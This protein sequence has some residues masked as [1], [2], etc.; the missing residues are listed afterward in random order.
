MKMLFAVAMFIF[1]AC[2]TT[3]MSKPIDNYPVFLKEGHRGARGYVPENTIASMKKGV[4]LG[5][6]VIEVDVYITRDG[7]VLI[8]HDPYV[9]RS[10]STIPGLNEISADSAKAYTWHQMNYT[11]IRRIDV[12]SKGNPAFPQ[13]VKQP[14]YM[15]LLGELIDS[16]ESYTRA[17]KKPVIYN[18]E[19]KA[20]PK[21]DGIYQP[22]AATIIKSVMEV[23]KSKNIG[24]RFY[25]QSFDKRQIQET[26]KSYPDVVTAYLVDSKT[27]SVDENLRELGYTPEIYSPHYK[28]VTAQT[29]A[30]CRKHKMKLVPW[31][32]NTRN[33]IDALILL[34]VDGIIT[35]YPDLIPAGK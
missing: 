34:G 13:Q 30:D 19:I 6:N 2:A 26:H 14:A 9:N 20:N 32:V 16:I 8:A 3:R 7:Q 28:L 22:D 31:T 27:M 11:D 4:D 1:T 5:V 23:V 33:E 18:I 10:I 24:N 12:G 17:G 21:F 25:I 35:D 29:V 15:P